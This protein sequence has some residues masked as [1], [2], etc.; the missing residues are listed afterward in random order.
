MRVM[1]LDNNYNILGLNGTDDKLF[2][3]RADEEAGADNVVWL[4]ETDEYKERCV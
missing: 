1:M 2:Y 4:Y 3:Y